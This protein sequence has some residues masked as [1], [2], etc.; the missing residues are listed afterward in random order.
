MAA[1]KELRITDPY[2]LKKLEALRTITGDR[3]SAKIAGRMLIERMAQIELHG[4]AL[5]NHFGTQPVGPIDARSTGMASA[6]A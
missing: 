1:L 3:C 6:V 2:L 5:P 4:T